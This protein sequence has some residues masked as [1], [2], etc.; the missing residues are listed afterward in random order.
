MKVKFHI[1][2]IGVDKLSMRLKNKNLCCINFDGKFDDRGKKY[3]CDLWEKNYPVIPSVND[4]S[5]FDKIPKKE[6]YILKLL[7]SYDGVGQLKLNE[8]EVKDK[9]N[10]NYI[11]QPYMK[12]I[13]EVQFYFVGTKF[14]Y[15]LEFKPSKIPIYPDAIPYSYNEEELEIAMSFAKLN[16]GF[17]GIQRIDF[18]KL[19]NGKLLL[20]E[21]EDSSPYL[22]LD[23]VSMETRNRFIEDYK[24][25]VYEYYKNY[26]NK[27]RKNKI[28]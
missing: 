18:I 27:M 12:F 6:Y 1:V 17:N 25:M 19:E 4:I 20:L 3:L 14:E 2:I 13:S 16:K 22:D 11:I 24:N 26:L 9:F 5:K 8:K 28:I 15:A 23:R 10:E 7:D 21:I